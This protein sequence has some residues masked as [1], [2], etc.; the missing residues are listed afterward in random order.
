[1]WRRERGQGDLLRQLRREEP[2]QPPQYGRA[3]GRDTLRER[4]FDDNEIGFGTHKYEIV[5]GPHENGTMCL[6]KLNLRT[7]HLGKWENWIL[8]RL[9]KL[10]AHLHLLVT[11]GLHVSGNVCSARNLNYSQLVV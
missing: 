10:A 7:Q 11:I 8:R 2:G 6:G 4:Y 3:R 9:P 1:M 5:V